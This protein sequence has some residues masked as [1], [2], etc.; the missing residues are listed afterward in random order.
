MITNREP[1]LKSAWLSP[2]VHGQH[3]IE[4]YRKSAFISTACTLLTQQIEL[5]WQND[6]L[7]VVGDS[8]Y[9]ERKIWK[10]TWSHSWRPNQIKL[11][12]I[13][14]IKSFAWDVLFDFAFGL[15]FSVL[16]FCWCWF[17]V[18]FFS[19]QSRGQRYFQLLRG[20]SNNCCSS[21]ARELTAK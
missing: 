21:T 8:Y 16:G 18:V 5:K 20:Y 12:I 11:L 3:I 13:S 4:H 17:W 14:T 19:I 15:E 9:R 10:I 7:V 6:I 2:L 1:T